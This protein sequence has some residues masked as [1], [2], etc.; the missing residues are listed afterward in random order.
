MTDDYK[1]D[2]SKEQDPWLGL[3]LLFITLYIAV[4]YIQYIHIIDTYNDI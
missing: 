2:Y 3:L 4:L 1:S